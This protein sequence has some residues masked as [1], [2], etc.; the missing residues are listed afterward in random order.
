LKKNNV[1]VIVIMVLFFGCETPGDKFPRFEVKETMLGK[2]NN[3]EIK[4]V[5]FINDQVGF[6][7][8]SKDTLMK[9]T[10]GCKTFTMALSDSSGGFEVIQFV[11]GNT[12]FVIDRNNFVYKTMDGGES[13]EKIK[14]EL[15]G[16]FLQDI[17]CVNQDTLFVV[18][19]GGS[20]VMDGYVI[21]SINGGKTWDTTRTINLSH[22]CFVSE[23]TGFACGSGGIIKTTDAG[24]TW[25]TISGLS[26]EDII[27]MDEL[28]GYFSDKRSL[29]K[30]IDGGR[31]WNLVKAI[32]NPSWIVGE[33]FSK[34]EGLNLINDKDLVFTL[35]SRLIKVTAEQ[36][37][38]QYEF[39]RP[40]YQ[41]QMIGLNKGIVYGFENLILVDF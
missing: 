34:I 16:A 3:H 18:A 8:I 30:T 14:I 38:F 22:I 37:W 27:F 36:K 4:D 31:N 20:Q 15:S 9:T 10:D 6:V 19:G 11:T 25:D 5:F 12:G 23:S 1:L 39:T 13:W 40:Y 29:F 28:N 2:I 33:D 32:V 24:K 41:L 26:A 7:A 17:K 35:N 21:K